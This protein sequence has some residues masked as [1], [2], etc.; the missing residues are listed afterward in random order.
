VERY[1]RLDREIDEAAGRFAEDVR[2]RRFPEAR[3]CFAM[4]E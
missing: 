2:E 4:R 3:L 1:A